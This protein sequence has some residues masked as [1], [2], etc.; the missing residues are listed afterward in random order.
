MRL[1]RFDLNLLV[2]LDTLL[3]ER[4]VTR[5]SE[6]LHVGQST[7]SDSNSRPWS[8]STGTLPFGFSA[9]KAGCCV[10]PS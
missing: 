4:N 1:D 6:R 8:S 7:A 10:L 9:R 3:E 5:P 2:V